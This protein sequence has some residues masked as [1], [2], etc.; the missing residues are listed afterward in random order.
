MTLFWKMSV[1]NGCENS[2]QAEFDRG[3]GSGKERV[4][5]VG[6]GPADPLRLSGAQYSLIESLQELASLAEAA[7]LE[8]CFSPLVL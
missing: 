3:D 6:V 2:T 4:V 5:L 8:V 1:V 7:G